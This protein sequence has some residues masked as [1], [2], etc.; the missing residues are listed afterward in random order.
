M[1]IS[2]QNMFIF[3]KYDH[4]ATK[5]IEDV[6]ENTK[7]SDI[8]QEK[9]TVHY[10]GNLVKNHASTLGGLGVKHGDTLGVR[11]ADTIQIFIDCSGLGV[12]PRVFC[13]SVHKSK[14]GIEI[15]KQIE[16]KTDVPTHYI[17]LISGTR[18]LEDYNTLSYYNIGDNSTIYANGRVVPCCIDSKGND[19]S[20]LHDYGTNIIS[21][22]SPPL[23]SYRIF[24]TDMHANILRGYHHV[25]SETLMFIVLDRMP[26]AYKVYVIH[27]GGIAQS[28]EYGVKNTDF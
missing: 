22:K 28:R 25:V 27:N 8:V 6:C 26:R 3:I 24:V 2:K 5:L 18:Y 10:R 9:S 4:G 20:I 21:L 23:M 1:Y 12:E 7:L 13:M 14:I 11:S 16:L 17:Y 15:K 19:V